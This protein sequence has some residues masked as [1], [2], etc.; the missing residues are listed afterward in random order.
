MTLLAALTALLAALVLNMPRAHLTS[1]QRALYAL[2]FTLLSAGTL[3][4]FFGAALSINAADHF[5]PIAV[6]L[7][8]AGAALSLLVLVKFG[9]ARVGPGQAPS[10]AGLGTFVIG[11]LAAVYLMFTVVDH[12]WFFRGPHTG[13][14]SPIAVG[15]K[16]VPCAYALVR[17]EPT[18]ETISYRCPTVL[19]FFQNSATPFVPW[20]AYTAGESASLKEALKDL[21]D[22]VTAAQ[23]K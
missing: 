6:W 7:L 14:T 4:L 18:S 8:L 11:S 1:L 23:D 3:T 2:S 12:L 5:A 21:M 10:A 13:W 17:M 9:P 22:E 16:D 19:A 15:A 20:P